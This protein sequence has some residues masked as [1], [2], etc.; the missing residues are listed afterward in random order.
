MIIAVAIVI[1]IVTIIVIIACYKSAVI[2][3]ETSDFCIKKNKD[4]VD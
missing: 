1:I 3:I 2:Y 4:K